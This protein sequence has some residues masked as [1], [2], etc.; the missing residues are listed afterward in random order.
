M[1]QPCTIR[2]RFVSSVFA[3]NDRNEGVHTGPLIRLFEQPEVANFSFVLV[4]RLPR[5]CVVNL[6]TCDTGALSSSSP[7]HCST[8]QGLLLLPASRRCLSCPSAMATSGRKKP[9][10]H[11]LMART[12]KTKRQTTR[13]A[14]V[15]ATAAPLCQGCVSMPVPVLT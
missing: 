12:L 2:F 14:Y 5:C 4:W 8:G 15:G 13:K 6:L 11:T 10:Y 3:S 9:C 7:L 1:T